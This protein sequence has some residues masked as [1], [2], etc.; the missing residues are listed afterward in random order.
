LPG[1]AVRDAPSRQRTLESAVAWSHDLLDP[2]R[3]RLLHELA[4][5]D[6]GF[7]LEQVD[8][9]SAAAGSAADRLDDLLELAD[10]SLIVAVPEAG[11]RA[12]FR[13]LRTIQTFALARLAADGDDP[14][15]RHRHAEAFLDLATAGTEDLNTSRH[16][17][18]LDR[19]GPDVANLRAAQHWAIDAGETDLALR[20]AGCMWRFWNAF[21]LGAEGRRL[22]EAALDMPV[23]AESTGARAWA[24]AAAG[25]L[26]YW[27]A[28]PLGARARYEEQLLLAKA[29]GDEACVVDALFNLGHVSFISGEPESVQRAY[30]DEVVARYR[31]LGDARGEA[32]AVWTRAILA[33]G[34]GRPEEGAEVLRH[35]IV[36]FDRLDDRQYHAMSVATLGWAAFVMGD[37]VTAIRESIAG[38]AES[39]AMRDLATTTISLHVGVMVAALAER[40]E[41]AAELAGA[42]EASCERYGVRPP[43]GLDRFV[44]NNDPVSASKVSLA[45]EVFAAAYERGRRLS[46]DEAVATVV[47]I[48][49]MAIA[50]APGPGA[51]AAGQ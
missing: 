23:S 34:N 22:T 20:L 12:R 15:V 33:I 49:E 11:G 3:Q 47:E 36:E 38:L 2:A 4:V 35:E 41:V 43:A 32:R 5:F 24:A 1:P 50:Q 13:M 37:T 48:G 29:A 26:A 46:L 16:P 39:H 25:S 27:Q 21:G 8:A 51:P 31:D 28:D 30:I 14:Q 10:R 19:V 42:F 44:L 7:D 6:G 45:P 18:I 9:M 40:W 17:L